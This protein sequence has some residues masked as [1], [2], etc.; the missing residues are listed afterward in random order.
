[1]IDGHLFHKEII[2]SK[3]NQVSQPRFDKPVTDTPQSEQNAGVQSRHTP[4]KEPCLF[5]A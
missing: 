4:C 5:I 1:M 2:T 3:G